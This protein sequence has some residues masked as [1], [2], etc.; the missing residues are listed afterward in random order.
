MIKSP[1]GGGRGR[2]SLGESTA[3]GASS[4]RNVLCF[5]RGKKSGLGGLLGPMRLI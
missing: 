3:V 5:F 1:T 2:D 4:A